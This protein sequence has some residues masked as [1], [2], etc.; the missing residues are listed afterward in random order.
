M[1]QL[2]CLTIKAKEPRR[3]ADF[4]RRVFE[5]KTVSE[6]DSLVRL[7]DGIFTLA[8][9]KANGEG[10]S[11]LD[12]SGFRVEDL[13]GIKGKATPAENGSA[14]YS[15]GRVADPDGNRIDLSRQ[16]FGV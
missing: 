9:L 13:D 6:D 5:V 1:P 14:P 15:E 10:R 3:L 8:L 7:S 16:S 12:A 11:G 4:Y 2:R